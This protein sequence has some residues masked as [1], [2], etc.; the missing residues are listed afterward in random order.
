MQDYNK[1]T[2][3]R[4]FGRDI[5]VSTKQS[6]EVCSFIRRKTSVNAKKLL[7]KV[8]KKEI[9]IPYKRYNKDIPH[10]K[11]KIMS[12]R[13]PIKTVKHII[14]LIESAEANAENKGLTNNLIIKHISAYKAATPWHHGRKRRRKM[15]R[16]NIEIVLEEI[17]TPKTEKETKEKVKETKKD[18]KETNKTKG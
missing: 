6:V 10:R 11:G 2:M 18:G 12:G 15:K 9:A 17:K 1:E 8:V 5:P 4:V 16:T 14:D 7:N 3:S 13:Y